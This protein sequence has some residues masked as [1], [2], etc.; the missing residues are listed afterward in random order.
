M[1][2]FGEID[3]NPSLEDMAK[4]DEQLTRLGKLHQF[5]TY[6]DADHRFADFTFTNYQKAADELAWSRTLEFF[7]ANLKGTAAA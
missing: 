5:Y 6:P 4:F 7:S 2:H 3:R 1:Y